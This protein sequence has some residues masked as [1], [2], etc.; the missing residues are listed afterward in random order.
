MRCYFNVRLKADI[1][2]LNLPHGKKKTKKWKKKNQKVKSDMLRSIDNI[3]RDVWLHVRQKCQIQM[4]VLWPRCGLSLP[5]LWQLIIIVVITVVVVVILLQFLSRAS[6]C[7]NGSC[8]LQHRS[9]C[10][11]HCSS[12]QLFHCSERRYV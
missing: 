10:T 6:V 9:T 5:I 11:C 3:Y 4:S 7:S 12:I 8:C 1:S 2:Q